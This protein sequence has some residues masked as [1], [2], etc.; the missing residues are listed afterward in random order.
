[1]L[2][3]CEYDREAGISGVKNE[4]EIVEESLKREDAQRSCET[5]SVQCGALASSEESRSSS[6]HKLHF[7]R[8]R[9]QTESAFSISEGGVASESDSTSGK[10]RIGSKPEQGS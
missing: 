1:M 8:Q 2:T 10:H 7:C 6:L 5:M 4:G 9:I 3:R